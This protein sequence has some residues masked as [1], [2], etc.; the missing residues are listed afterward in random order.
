[1]MCQPRVDR[2]ELKFDYKSQVVA[3]GIKGWYYD[4]S[5]G[6]WIG[7]AYAYLQ[8][9]CRTIQLCKWNN[10]GTDY[11]TLIIKYSGGEFEYPAISYNWIPYNEYTCVIMRK[12][13]LEKIRNPDTSITFIY[14]KIYN[15]NHYHGRK[16]DNMLVYSLNGKL[17]YLDG[18]NRETNDYYFWIKKEGNMIRFDYNSSG[19][20]IDLWHKTFEEAREAAIKIWTNSYF[21][22]PLTEW[23]KLFIGLKEQ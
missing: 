15:Y 18:S 23:N 16:T 20:Y 10:Q 1:M 6:K 9:D 14:S 12:E 19:S 2:P 11:Y 4:I 8:K 17:K 5:T 22:I 7:R 3:N 21:E 13:D